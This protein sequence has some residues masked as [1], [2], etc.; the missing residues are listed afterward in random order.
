MSSEEHVKCTQLMLQLA[1][2]WHAEVRDITTGLPAAHG[3]YV[4]IASA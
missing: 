4:T 3:S 1:R 2:G